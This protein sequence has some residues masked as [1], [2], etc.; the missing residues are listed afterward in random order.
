M[1]NA[2]SS[3][4]THVFSSAKYPSLDQESDHRSVFTDIPAELQ[5][6][7]SSNYSVRSKHPFPDDKV[8]HYMLGT[9][10]FVYV[11]SSCNSIQVK[12]PLIKM[13]DSRTHI[14]ST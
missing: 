12:L 7:V 2:G 9:V 3:K 10:L 13:S 11:E 6:P 5:H 4:A 8:L 1:C 14:T